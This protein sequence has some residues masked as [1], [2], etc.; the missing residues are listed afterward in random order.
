MKNQNFVLYAK[1]F[2]APS[3]RIQGNQ[4]YLAKHAIEN[5]FYV[6]ENKAKSRKYMQQ[7]N[8]DEKETYSKKFWPDPPRG[9]Q[10]H[11]ARAS[12]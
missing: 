1:K 10:Q 2:R 9:G 7:K 8:F 11:I 3:A 12:A 4:S 6:E 5:I